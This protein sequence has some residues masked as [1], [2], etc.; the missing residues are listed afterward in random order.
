M[1]EKTIE[2]KKL[3]LEK[4]IQEIKEANEEI[5]QLQIAEDSDDSED[6]Q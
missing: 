3:S 4:C 2:L 6:E 5:G 1:E